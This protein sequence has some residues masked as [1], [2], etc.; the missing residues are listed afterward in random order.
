MVVFR[1]HKIVKHL[2]KTILREAAGV[3]EVAALGFPVLEAAVVEGFEVVRDNK[4]DDASSQAFFEQQQAA[5]TAVAVLEGMDALEAVV[6]I[7]QIVESLL[8]FGVV[9]PQQDLHGSGDVLRRGGISAADLVW[10]ALVVA[11]SKPI[12]A[13]VRRTVFQH[14]MELLDQAFGDGVIGCIDNQIDAAEVIRRLHHIVHPD[15]GVHAD[16]VRL[17]D[18]PGLVVR[19]AAALDVVGVVGQVDLDLVVDPAVELRCLLLPQNREQIPP[20]SVASRLADRFFGVLR[21]VPGLPREQSPG[22]SPLRTVIP[23]AAL[24]KPPAL[25]RLRNRNIVHFLHLRK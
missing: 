20:P 1:Y 3:T 22:D 25:R 7:Q 12:F 17:E 14:S 23:H 19:Q 15:R 5:D 21:H 18:Q 24:R 16:G 13:A 10:K 9:V 6:E 2:L 8:L 11:H 4:G